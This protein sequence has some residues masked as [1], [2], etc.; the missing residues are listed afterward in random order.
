[1]VQVLPAELIKQGQQTI[2]GNVMGLVP[3]NGSLTPRFILVGEAPGATEVTAQQPFTGRAGVELDKSLTQ[4]GVTRAD[5]FITSAYHSR[6]FR[7][8]T[9]THKRTGATYQKMDNRPPT[10]R[11]LMRQAFLLDYELAHLPTDLI[12]TIGNVGLQRLLGPTYR[13]GAVHGQLLTGPIQRYDTAKKVF[14]PTQKH[15][16]VMPTFHPAAVFYNRQIQADLTA[17]LAQFKQLL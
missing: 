7:V 17:D 13:V 12:L 4:L 5:I 15:Y 8:V 2:S 1:M 14:V 9:K 3:G 16:R 11:E 6:P 10:K